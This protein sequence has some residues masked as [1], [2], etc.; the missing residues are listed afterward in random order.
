MSSK[1][2]CSKCFRKQKQF[3]L[4]ETRNVMTSQ[5]FSCFL[6]QFTRHIINSPLVEAEAESYASL[7]QGN[8]NWCH[9]VSMGTQATWKMRWKSGNKRR[10]LGH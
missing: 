5:R 10:M 1:L 8:V 6:V 7:F 3:S 4:L 9:G 2:I